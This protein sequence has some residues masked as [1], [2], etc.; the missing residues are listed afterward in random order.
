MQGFD[1]INFSNYTQNDEI[2]RGVDSFEPVVE[3]KSSLGWASSGS[4]WFGSHTLP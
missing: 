4:V 3:G 1:D 2:T